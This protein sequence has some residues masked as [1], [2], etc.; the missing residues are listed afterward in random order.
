MRVA[1]RNASAMKPETSKAKAGVRSIVLFRT[2]LAATKRMVPTFLSSAFP[3]TEATRMDF[4]NALA[5][6]SVA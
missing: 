5:A 6:K 3:A 4:S 2:A 1:R